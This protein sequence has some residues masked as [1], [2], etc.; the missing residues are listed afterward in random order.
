MTGR[1]R[2]K[3]TVANPMDD[4]ITK[5]VRM[6]TK[7]EH[8]QKVTDEQASDIRDLRQQVAM[9]KGG[10]RVLLW[11]GGIVGGLIAAWT[12]FIEFFK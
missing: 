9:G 5:L 1:G 7:L 2:P 6:E 3:K 4:I 11:V 12:A 8:I 10:L